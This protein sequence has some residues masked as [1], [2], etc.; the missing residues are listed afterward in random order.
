M[1][2]EYPVTPWQNVGDGRAGA[3]ERY[4]LGPDDG[5][6][7]APMPV[8]AAAEVN[9]AYSGLLAKSGADK[10][11]VRCGDG[12]GP[13]KNVRDVPMKRDQ[14]TGEWTATVRAGAERGTL[15]FCFH[16]G[17]GNWD[18]N[19]GRN[20][21]VTVHGGGRRATSQEPLNS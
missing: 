13:W 16:D 20:W 8:T 1:A 4:Q 5:V 12:P 19:G 2:E 10:L 14:E 3:A 11:Y 9:I 6:R 17:A 18:N 7:V 21:S 15:E